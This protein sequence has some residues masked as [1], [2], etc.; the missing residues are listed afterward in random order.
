MNLLDG[1]KDDTFHVTR[2]SY[3]HMSDSEWEVVGRMSGLMGEPAIS[4][5][6]EP[7]D[8][9]GHHTAINN[10]VEGKLLLNDRR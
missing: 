6:L 2:E 1:D 8:E 5:N 7:L 4:G 10:F 3:F 9:D